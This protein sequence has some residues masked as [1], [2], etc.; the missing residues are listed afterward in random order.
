VDAMNDKVPEYRQRY[1]DYIQHEVKATTKALKRRSPKAKLFHEVERF[2]DMLSPLKPLASP[3]PPN[4]HGICLGARSGVEVQVLRDWGYRAIGIDVVANPPLVLLGDFHNIPFPDDT[5][6]FAFSNSTGHTYDTERFMTEI[7]RVLKPDAYVLFYVRT[8]FRQDHTRPVQ[9]V[10]T[11]HA[12]QMTEL[13]GKHRFWVISDEHLS[14]PIHGG[15]S[16]SML[17]QRRKES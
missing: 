8:H 2:R 4:S 13:L 1:T 12:N 16:R 5:F 3:M 17:A 9:E 6:D 7:S 10:I 11:E 15:R 14:P